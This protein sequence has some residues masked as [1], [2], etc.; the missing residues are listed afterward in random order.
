ML[1]VNLK[2][3]WPWPEWEAE[4]QIGK[5][6]FGVVYKAVRREHNIESTAA[7]KV[8]SI[9]SDS[10]EID[11]LRSEGLNLDSTRAY[12]QSVVDDFVSEIQLMET[13]KGTQNIVSVED[14]KV[15]E[16]TKDIGWDI[17]IRMELLQP[18]SSYIA[19]KKMTEAEVINLGI[20]LCSALEVCGKRNII[21]RD[22]K[23]ENIFINSFGDFKLGDFGIARKMENMTG[24][25]SQKGTYNYMAPEV[26]NSG[27]YDARVDIYSL[28]IVL[29]RL[30]NDNRLPFIETEQQLLNPNERRNAVERRLRGEALVPPCNASKDVAGI[31]MCA[32]AYKPEARFSN[33]TAMKNALIDAANKK[34]N[35][36]AVARQPVVKNDVNPDYTTAVRKMNVDNNAAT[37]K[38][39]TAAV[40]A[41]TPVVTQPPVVTVAPVNPVQQ[42][43]PANVNTPAKAPANNKKPVDAAAKKK[44]KKKTIRILITVLVLIILLGIG[45]LVG[46][47]Y[48]E[49]QKEQE[50]DINK[51]ISEVQVMIQEKN[52][53]D[54]FKAIKDGI[55]KYPD[56]E[57]LKEKQDE[58]EEAEI[59]NIISEA[60]ALAKDKKY[61]E[62]IK[63]ANKGLE[64][65]PDS[66]ELKKKKAEFEKSLADKNQAI[67]E[68]IEAI[69]ADAKALADKGDYEG[70]LETIEEGLE[71]YTDS[72]DLIAKKD[73]YIA[74]LA[75][76]TKT[77]VLTE[78]AGFAESGDYVSAMKVIKTAQTKY[79]DCKEYTDAY[80]NYEATYINETIAET[81]K[82]LEANRFDDAEAFLTEA[83]ENVSDDTL[84][85]EKINGIKD[86]KPTKLNALYVI[87]SYS[88]EYKNEPFTNSYGSVYNGYYLF[89]GNNSYTLLNLNKEY[90]TLAGSV[91]PSTDTNGK[92]CVFNIYVDDELVFTQE[93]DKTTEVVNFEVDVKNKKTLK[94]V[95]S[96]GDSYSYLGVVDTY[97]TK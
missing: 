16:R 2:S 22:I 13:L 71:T 79:G 92:V 78:A 26:A 34:G 11:S 48:L 73:E 74:I 53:D 83:K 24:G 84:I 97:L 57:S 62:A 18:F 95:V 76:E 85:T 51:I 70:A 42:P 43:Q 69:I 87:D 1:N 41:Q 28:G 63:A 39:P 6:S 49:N 75:D 25:L 31:V 56:A 64:K 93:I 20:D 60:Q 89:R 30:L 32:C 5:G 66:E 19:N 36:K 3:E 29:Y 50:S 77:G 91:C 81:D 55:E 90:S 72:A 9:P 80:G 40:V 4:K 46:Y 44:K 27:N 7:I 88:S 65:Y 58:I 94:I 8:I 15:V 38:I 54:A 82:M 67:Q 35:T 21:H 37:A 96:G 14:Y 33:A 86:L 45:G 52:Y 10:S 68:S 17:Y 59:K 61:S 47:F 23:P 12:L